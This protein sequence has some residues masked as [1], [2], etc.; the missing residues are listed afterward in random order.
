[1]HPHGLLSLLPAALA[2][3]LAL[4]TRNVLLSLLAA[5]WAAGTLLE[6]WNPLAGALR[7]VDPFLLDALADRD[8]MKVT[9][10]SLLI[11]AMV[12]VLSGAGATRALVEQLLRVAKGR[13]SG[14]LAAWLGGLIVFFDDYANCLIVG[15]AMRPLF[16]RLRISRE[17]LAYIVDSTAAPI[18]SVALVSTWVGYEVGLMKDGLTSAGQ[19]LDAYAWFVEGIPY[20]FYSLYTIAFVLAV[21]VL[22]RDF[23]PMAAA[24]ARALQQPAD[25]GEAAPTGGGWLALSAALPILTLIGVTFAEMIRTGTEAAPEAT[26]LAEILGAAAGYDAMLRG[27]LAALALAGA[28]AVGVARLS[29][30]RVFEEGVR[31][32]SLLFEALAV[33]FLAWSLGASIGALDAA[34]YLVQ[35]LSGALHPGL[36]PTLIF[37]LCAGISFA[38]G[39][40]F[41]TM[42]IVMPMAI[43]LSFALTADPVLQLAAAGAVL[44]GSCWGDHCSPISDTTVLSSVGSGCDLVAHTETQLPYAL[45]CGLIAVVFGTL[46]VGFGV[47]VWVVLPLGVVACFAAMWALGRPLSAGSLPGSAPQSP[48]A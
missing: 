26:R 5:V 41:G 18:A 7:V 48:A 15:N 38:T 42:A 24:E 44:S 17:K 10:F 45:V 11:A 23:G 4:K 20:R 29:T 47:P 16:D 30:A 8:H 46:P 2:I 37:V 39:T 31:G 6:G 35:A 3:A 32:M 33:L 13:R 1:M 27:S 43:P 21:A 25:A 9:L 36:L 40:S 12:G 34:G 28:L 19:T 22:G 14:M